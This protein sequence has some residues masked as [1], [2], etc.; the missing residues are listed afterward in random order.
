VPVQQGSVAPPV[1]EVLSNPR[2]AYNDPF[3]ALQFK[4]WDYAAGSVRAS[5]GTV[6]V[7]GKPDWAAYLNRGLRRGEAVLVLFQYTEDADAVINLHSG[8]WQQPNYREWGIGVNGGIQTHGFYGADWFGGQYLLG[9][10]VA[11]AGEWTYA[12]IAADADGHCVVRVWAR[13]NP[14]ETMIYRQALGGWAAQELG[15]GIG[16]NHGEITV[17]AYTTLSFDGFVPLSDAEARF[18]AGEAHYRD[19]AYEAALSEFNIAIMQ[20]TSNPLAY[21]RRGNS[22]ANMGKYDNATADW[23]QAIEIDPDYW[24]GHNNLAWIYLEIYQD[25]GQT[26]AHA[27]RVID[28]VPELAAGYRYRAL[29]NRD[30]EGGNPAAAVADLDRAIEIEPWDAGHYLDRCIVYINLENHT[31]ALSD[32]NRCLDIDPEY[33]WCYWQ[34]GWAHNSMGT[35]QAAASDYARFLELV[36]PEECPECQEDARTYIAE[37]GQ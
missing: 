37:H 5:N 11:H 33:S 10:M 1:S 24:I 32:C 20:D 8:E 13:D 17:D 36:G 12:L 35:T 34:R 29:A 7:T 26:V 31:Q 23:K 19:G 22:H 28:L 3:D 16:A 30:L 14:A 6:I 21:H 2:V 25:Y 9:G 18:W 4:E 27:G 15:F